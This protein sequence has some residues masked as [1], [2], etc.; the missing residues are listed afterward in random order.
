MVKR[1]QLPIKSCVRTRVCI[2]NVCVVA[3]VA[4]CSPTCTFVRAG[5][6][7]D[8]LLATT[9]PRRGTSGRSPGRCTWFGH[10]ARPHPHSHRTR[11]DQHLHSTRK[12]K[13][14]HHQVSIVV[15][16][17]T[18]DI[19]TPFFFEVTSFAGCRVTDRSDGSER[20]EWDFRSLSTVDLLN[21]AGPDDAAAKS[22]TSASE[23]RHLSACRS[24]PS[25]L[26]LF[27][28][29]D[30]LSLGVPCDVILDREHQRM[31]LSHWPQR[32]KMQALRLTFGWSCA[33]I[34]EPSV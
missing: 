17:V 27:C 34:T 7:D 31:G 25:S 15:R 1:G 9:Q 21:L 13:P 16:A 11:R 2:M 23:V 30:R 26:H 19:V 14:F 6:T 5:W 22:V 3:V 33:M 28:Y 4:L 29:V 24:V 8:R 18:V 12:T 32:L 10:S 20:F